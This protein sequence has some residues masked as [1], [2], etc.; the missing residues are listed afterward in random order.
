M[1]QIEVCPGNLT[2][3]YDTF[4]PPCLK[5]LFDGKRV[6]PVL[7]F[8]YDADSIDLAESINQISISG[9]QEKLSAVVQNGQIVLTH[10]VNMDTTSSSL[11]QVIKTYDSGTLYLQMNIS[12]CK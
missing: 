11:H 7:R 1:K 9:V 12:Q 2:P 10:R 4:S 5:K 6:S 8:D 3:G